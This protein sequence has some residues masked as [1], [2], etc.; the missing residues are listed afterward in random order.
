MTE[1]YVAL[2]LMQIAGRTDPSL[3][4]D[5]D[6]PGRDGRQMGGLFLFSEERAERCLWGDRGSASPSPHPF[7]KGGNHGWDVTLIANY[8]ILCPCAWS[9][10]LI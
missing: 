7:R 5:R 10:T 1:L 6:G 9:L 2:R 3:L 8:E 4:G